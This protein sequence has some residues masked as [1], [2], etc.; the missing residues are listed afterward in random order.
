MFCDP[1]RN[2]GACCR[3]CTI[4]PAPGTL[5]AGTAQSCCPCPWAF[6]SQEDLSCWLNMLVE[7]MHLETGE[8]KLPTSQSQLHWKRS[9]NRE[10]PKSFIFYFQNVSW[11][12]GNTSER[13]KS[14]CE[15]KS[16]EKFCAPSAF[17]AFQSAADSVTAFTAA[18]LGLLLAASAIQ[19]AVAHLN[20]EISWSCL[21][22]TAGVTFHGGHCLPAKEHL[23]SS[24]GQSWCVHSPTTWPHPS[25]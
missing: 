8:K 15:T 4:P 23:G 18:R 6:C 11:S 7:V 13:E 1:R 3:R 16:W 25:L 9:P 5:S 17:C 10:L 22:G 19:T 2:I 20:E 21:A 24:A 12:E 14:S